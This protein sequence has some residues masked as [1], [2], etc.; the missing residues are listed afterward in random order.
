M[1]GRITFR[2]SKSVVEIKLEAADVIKEGFAGV[3]DCVYWG[4]PDFIDC[5]D[6]KVTFS[7][8]LVEGVGI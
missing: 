2:R 7:R 1:G 8:A 4:S 3:D 6:C 5:C